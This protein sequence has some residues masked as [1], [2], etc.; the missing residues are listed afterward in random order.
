MN[1]KVAYLRLIVQSFRPEGFGVNPLCC[2]PLNAV[3]Y[4]TASVQRRRVIASI[5]MHAVEQQRHACNIMYSN[6]SL[7]RLH[8]SPRNL[9]LYQ[10]VLTQGYCYS[11]NAVI[12]SQ[13]LCP[14]IKIVLVKSF[15]ASRS[16][17]TIQCIK[18]HLRAIQLA[19]SL[20]WHK[21]HDYTS[22]HLCLQRGVSCIAWRQGQLHLWMKLQCMYR[23]THAAT[24]SE[25]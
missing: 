23:W 8:W 2:S 1:P 3:K 20:T 6:F 4:G 15:L 13:S 25:M 21:W 19:F 9:S 24:G 22:Q 18:A 10:I 5:Q 17:C 14:Y 16:W 11:Q 12:G 7:W